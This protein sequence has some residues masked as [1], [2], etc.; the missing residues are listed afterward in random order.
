[1]VSLTPRLLCPGKRTSSAHWIRKVGWAPKPVQRHRPEETTVRA[2]DRAPFVQYVVSHYTDYLPCTQTYGTSKTH[3]SSYQ[4][5]TL[6]IPFFVSHLTS[7]ISY[8]S[9]TAQDNKLLSY[10]IC[11][12]FCTRAATEPAA[13][14]HIS[15]GRCCRPLWPEMYGRW[16]D[17]FVPQWVTQNMWEELIKSHISRRGFPSWFH[18][19][20]FT[21][22]HVL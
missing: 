13:W 5:L 2:N 10:W 14:S 1:M 7:T 9:L 21:H 12:A 17:P 16:T 6:V 18:E 20:I 11:K 22:G 19:M 3:S 8:Q 4:K 15:S